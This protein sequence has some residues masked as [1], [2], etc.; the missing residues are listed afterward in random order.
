MAS[1]LEYAKHL[2]DE[3]KICAWAFN[4]VD[5]TNNGDWRLCCKSYKLATKEKYDTIVE[6]WNGDEAVDIRKKMISNESHPVCQKIC[7]SQEKEGYPTTH[8]QKENINFAVT[9]GKNALEQKIKNTDEDGKL[10]IGHLNSIELRISNLCNLKCRMCSPKFSTKL[11]KDWKKILPVIVETTTDQYLRAA[12]EQQNEKYEETP[13]SRLE[14]EEVKDILNVVGPNL[15]H[16]VF[17]G[18]EPFME[19]YLYNAIEELLPFAKNIKLQFVSNG[20]KLDNIEEFNYLFQKFKR[21]DISLSCDGIENTYNYIRQESKWEHF[22]DQA[23]LLYNYDLYLNFHIVVQIY[24]YNNIINTVEWVIQNFKDATIRFTVLDQSPYLSIYCLPKD[25]KEKM[26]NELLAYAAEILSY[27]N[28][29]SFTKK[30][31][32]E[33]LIRIANKISYKED[34]RLLN[35]FA[36]VSDKYDEIQKVPITWRQLLPELNESLSKDSLAKHA[37]E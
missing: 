8:R 29:D 7:Y 16:I 9:R 17:T 13:L 10:D 18:G 35:Q 15:E 21:V 27:N 6:F 33:E 14:Y 19:P 11:N 22:S 23:L 34:Q 36:V 37:T 1:D 3:T 28:I 25:I 2:N 31:V 5:Y 32:N 26:K 24:N 4:H 12:Y 30:T 20:T